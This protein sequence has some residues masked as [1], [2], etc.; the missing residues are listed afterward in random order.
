MDLDRKEIE[1]LMSEN[2]VTAV[3]SL[4]TRSG[5]FQIIAFSWGDDIALVR[6]KVL[7]RSNVPVR[8]HSQCLTG[9]TLGSQRCDCR[10]QLESAMKKLSKMKYGVLL[11][12]Q[13]EGRGIGLANKIKAY[14]LQ[15]K[16]YDT[17]E[18]N[19]ILGFKADER[20]YVIAAKML[21]ALGIKSIKLMT[22]NP[23][24]IS[25]LGRHGIKI[26]GRIPLT[27]KPNRY[28]KFYLE[29]KQ[30]HAKKMVDEYHQA[31]RFF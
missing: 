24:K 9:D 1:E 20:D 12:L 30:R 25:D 8:I 5:K 17:Y 18:A 23:T 3:A 13:Q 21:K 28:D 14:Q 26:T 19:K 16:G 6:G 29:T 4:P 15:D 31:E 10:A 11:Y 22:N 27:V 7:G 2:E